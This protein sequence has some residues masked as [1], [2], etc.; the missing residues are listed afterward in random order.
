M[1]KS[2]LWKTVVAFWLDGE[3]GVARSGREENGESAR[4]IFTWQHFSRTRRNNTVCGTSITTSEL[5]Q[6]TGRWGATWLYS[7]LA[8]YPHG[9]RNKTKEW[10]QKHIHALHALQ[11]DKDNAIPSFNG[12][13]FQS[14]MCSPGGLQIQGSRFINQ[15]SSISVDDR[16]LF[17][18]ILT[19]CFSSEVVTPIHSLPASPSIT[20][21]RTLH[22]TSPNTYKTYL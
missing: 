10:L 6:E 18:A 11:C 13:A 16:V 14:V 7:K 17:Y 22:N 15:Y 9:R 12:I 2:G 8:G 20:E 4:V 21:T 1:D 19:S 3:S 5:S